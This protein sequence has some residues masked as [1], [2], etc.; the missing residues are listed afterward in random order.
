MCDLSTFRI[1]V[2]K[3]RIMRGF[4]YLH[5]QG[6][7]LNPELILNAEKRASILADNP[8][9]KE[10]IKALARNIEIS[11]K[12]ILGTFLIL[13]GVFLFIYFKQR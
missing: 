2:L 11:M 9:H 5:Q 13:L 3:K 4:K 10:E 7:Q 1:V 8:D 12:L 6:I